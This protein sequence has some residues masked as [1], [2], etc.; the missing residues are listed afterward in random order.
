VKASAVIFVATFVEPCAWPGAVTEQAKGLFHTSPGQ[1]PGFIPPKIPL[2]A[3][4]LPQL[5][6]SQHRS[7]I[8]MQQA[9]RIGLTGRL[10]GL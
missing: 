6:S 7:I 8:P 5:S 4:G 1:R 10:S 2:Q 3:E 9:L